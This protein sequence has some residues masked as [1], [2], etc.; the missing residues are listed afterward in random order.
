MYMLKLEEYI[1]LSTLGYSRNRRV[2]EHQMA[3]Y[4]YNM[5]YIVSCLFIPSQ[6][7][8]Y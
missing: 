6:Y 8:V 1:K 5:V 7:D 3:L 4:I 2:A